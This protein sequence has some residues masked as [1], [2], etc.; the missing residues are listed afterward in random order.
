MTTTMSHESEACHAQR[1]Q[2]SRDIKES[3]L[4]RAEADFLLARLKVASS[5]GA[6]AVR[7]DFDEAM[8]RERRKA[9]PS[10][11]RRGATTMTQSGVP[12]N[13]RIRFFDVA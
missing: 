8:D 7:R 12:M 1:D 2:L 5:E 11:R 6:A 13:K 4:P 3:I 10:W 9:L